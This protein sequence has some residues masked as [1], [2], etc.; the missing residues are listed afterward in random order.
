MAYNIKQQ[1]EFLKDL[2]KYLEKN[3]LEQDYEQNLINTFSSSNLS[4]LY[5][6]FLK[7]K[8]YSLSDDLYNKLETIIATNFSINSKIILD[9]KSDCIEE[10]NIHA[11][12]NIIKD[13]YLEYIAADSDEITDEEL[14]NLSVIVNKVF[15]EVFLKLVHTPSNDIEA[16]Q[17]IIREKIL[18]T[19][20]HWHL[21]SSDSA[22]IETKDIA[23]AF[24]ITAKKLYPH[25]NIYIPGRVKSMRSSLININK[26]ISKSLSS[27]IPTD[28]SVGITTE[29]VKNQFSLNDANT[30]FSGIT[31]VLNNVD[32]SF[33]LD[34][35]DPRSTEILKLR[36][37]RNDNLNFTHTLENFLADHE[38]TDLSN[39]D[40]LQIKIDLLTRLR[41]SSYDECTIEYH[42]TSFA[43]L[44]KSSIE[45]YQYELNYE[46]EPIS[47]DKNLYMLKIDEIYEL[48]DEL[49]KRVHDKY[50]TKI[51][52]MAI[53]DILNDEIFSEILKVKPKFIKNIR[54]KNG[55]C[56]LYYSLVTL[57]GRKIELQAQSKKRFEDSKNGPSDHSNLPNKNIDISDFFEPV[58]PDC[59]E[60][61]F[62]TLLNIL[63]NTSITTRNVLYRTPDLQLPPTDKRLKRRIKIAEQ[64]IKLKDNIE[65]TT[66]SNDG[67]TQTTLYPIEKYLPLF[68]EY[69]S[70]QSF[71]ISSP[72][73]RFNNG[74]AGY[75]K[76]SIISSFT[77][78]L[79]KHDST[80]CLS[81]ILIDKLQEILPNE[82]KN[83]VSKHGIIKRSTSRY[84]HLPI[85][86]D[87]IEL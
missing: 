16:Q 59:D 13:K 60:T 14:Y 27:M 33:H 75:N 18:T 8:N 43:Q 22:Q 42:N 50:Q 55:F 30:D 25:L 41:D 24:Y 63:N 72:H 86:S 6:L 3:P 69:I 84:G 37:I 31:I 38:D 28:S 66:V 4:D 19:I 48:L 10:E 26:E 73:T 34:K 12:E 56:S 23:G 57:D 71:T 81:Q 1:E 67:T 20:D 54:K 58:D 78:V 17:A 45:E 85:D 76:K 29:D 46:T 49:R 65:V 53:P 15:P 70:P 51:L 35:N 62:K 80:T 11:L 74:I 61:Q 40:L 64:N 77:D 52:E 2:N 5:K 83:E 36:K 32:D 68:A 44:L 9:L 21:H 87:E 47:D 79:L 7:L 39:T 82:N